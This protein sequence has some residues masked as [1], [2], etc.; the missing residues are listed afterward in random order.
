[1]NVLK[2]SENVVGAITRGLA[3]FCLFVVFLLFLLN[4]CT[5]LPFITWNPTWIDEVIQF[6][7][8]WMI[9]LGAMELVRTGGHF[10]VDILTDK[11][12]GT[13][14]GRVFRI[15]STLIMLF[16]YGIIF[17]FSVRLCM[18]STMKATFTLPSFVNMAWFYSCIPVTTLFMTLYT[19]RDV[20]LAFL[21]LITGGKITQQQDA[22]KAAAALEDEDAKAIAEAAAALKADEEK[23]RE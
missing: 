10:M 9:F 18:T 11:L 2:K 7:L 14:L 23:E 1:M 20:V 19:L 12:H 15:V 21:D 17:F 5:R 16:T 6:F 22:A 8:V 4:I 3:A 13:L